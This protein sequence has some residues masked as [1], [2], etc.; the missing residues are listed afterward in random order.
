MASRLLIVDDEEFHMQALCDTLRDHEYEVTGFTSAEKALAAVR[1]G[2]FDLLL[3]DLMMPEMD[4]ISLLR[5]AQEIDRDLVGVVMTGHGAI[6]TAVEAMKAGALDY[7]LKPFKLSVILPVLS[8]AL[9]VRSLRMENIQLRQTVAIY[10]LSAAMAFAPDFNSVLQ[11]LLDSAYVQSENGQV[12][13][14][15][16]GENDGRLI[17]AAARGEGAEL[18]YGRC[19]DVDEV[20]S[21]WVENWRET[22]PDAWA[23]SRLPFDHPLRSITAGIAMPLLA[24]GRLV[25]VLTFSSGHSNRPIARREAKTLNILAGAAASAMANEQHMEQ[26]RELNAELEARVAERTRQL[27]EKNRQIEEELSMAREL[28]VAMLPHRFPCVPRDATPAQSA[29]RFY[30]VY[31][32][33]GSVS[34]DFFDVIPLSDSSVGI[35]ISDVMGHDVRAALVTSMMRVLVQELSATLTEPGALLSEVNRHLTIN[36]KHADPMMFATATYLV[37]NLEKSQM[38]YANAGHPPPIHIRRNQGEAQPIC[39]N[40]DSGP[41]LGIFD[42]ATYKTCKATLSA[43]DCI[44]LFTDGLFEVEAAADH[45]D[46]Y[47]QERLR[48]AISQRLDLPADELFNKIFAEIRQFSGQRDFDDDV[49]LLAVEVSRVAQMAQGLPN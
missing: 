4:G 24:G 18:L 25:G 38:L 14:L 9:A 6:D 23:E 33:A 22:K 48:L 3:T 44:M 1:E 16:P 35:F 31:H 5:E 39:R 32:P 41:A 17:V 30:S 37:V 11:A 8:R 28:Q 42:G 46:L 13:I 36:L 27:Q 21:A 2:E 47:S 10:E 34:G 20:L 40:G 26:L 29:V 49:C 12:S 43:G 19:I 15:L 7:I 45:D